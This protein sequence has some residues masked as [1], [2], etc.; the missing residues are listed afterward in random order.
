ML[1]IQG[2]IMV[3]IRGFSFPSLSSDPHHFESMVQTPVQSP[4][5]GDSRST[6]SL[7]W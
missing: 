1:R 7:D 5:G 6:A 3:E 4:V 2:Q